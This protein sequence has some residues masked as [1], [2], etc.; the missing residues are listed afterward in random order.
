MI[1]TSVFVGVSLDGFIARADDGL[2]WLTG[3]EGEEVEAH[4]FEE[5]F[6]TVDALLMGRRTYDVVLGLGPWYYGD[7]PVFVLSSKP[8]AEAPAGRNVERITGDP[9]EVL[10]QLEARGF[11]HVYVD[12]G[13]TIQSFLRAGRVDRLT[14]SALPILIGT[15]IPLFGPTG[16]DIRLR[17]EA[18]RTFKGGMVQSEYEVIHTPEKS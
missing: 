16:R 12:G 7:K 11:G 13:L 17:H 1:R 4:G 3:G 18:T 2:D 8:I 10:A 15:G 14:L 9:D 5:F 6:A